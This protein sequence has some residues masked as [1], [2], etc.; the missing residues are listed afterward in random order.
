MALFSYRPASLLRNR[1]RETKTR[2][3]EQR[4]AGKAANR[5]NTM[6]RA[7]QLIIIDRTFRYGPQTQAMQNA[8]QLFL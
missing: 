8:R 2:R 5:S 7:P 6:R 4:Q 1:K 3:I